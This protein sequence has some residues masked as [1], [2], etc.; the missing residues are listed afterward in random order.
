MLDA[1]QIQ[2]YTGTDLAFSTQPPLFPMFPMPICEGNGGNSSSA[3]IFEQL[4]RE[5][6]HG[7]EERSVTRALFFVCV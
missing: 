1:V 4:A 7:I 2:A 6:W 3:V 5:R